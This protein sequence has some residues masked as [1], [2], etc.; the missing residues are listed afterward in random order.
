[1]AITVI[2]VIKKKTPDEQECLNNNEK[3]LFVVHYYVGSEKPFPNA[4]A[5]MDP[6]ALQYGSE[7][8]EGTVDPNRSYTSPKGPSG[9]IHYGHENFYD[10]ASGS[11]Y[12][13]SGSAG[14]Y[15]QSTATGGNYHNVNHT[16]HMSQQGHEQHYG[17]SP[18][19][20]APH[21]STTPQPL[22]P[23]S[24]FR[25]SSNGTVVAPTTNPALYNPTLSHQHNMQNDTLVG[26][27]L[28]TVI[29]LFLSFYLLLII[30][31]AFVITKKNFLKISCILKTCRCIL[32]IKASAVIVL[33]HQ[34]P[35]IHHHH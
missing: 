17:M 23:M 29:K 35:S 33:I 18:H 5:A 14:N 24:S 8:F 11:W 1:M 13:Q 20:E 30:M 21:M 16:P 25:G 32:M 27:A 31:N 7:E 19:M 10:A 28:Q 34:R 12:S 9:G 3:S 4:Y 6:V 15:A 22:P 2:I 26:K